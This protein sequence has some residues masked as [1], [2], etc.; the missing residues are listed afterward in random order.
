MIRRLLKLLGLRIVYVC[1]WGTY[2]HRYD[3]IDRHMGRP[4]HPSMSV[5]PPW[6]KLR[7]ERATGQEGGKP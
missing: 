5:A 7:I 3:G 2:S 4:I 6:A 1:D